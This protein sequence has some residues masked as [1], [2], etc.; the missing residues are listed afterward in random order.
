MLLLSINVEHTFI[1]LD[2]E[3]VVLSEIFVVLCFVYYIEQI[4]DNHYIEITLSDFQ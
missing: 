1:L 2:L 3:F 4:N